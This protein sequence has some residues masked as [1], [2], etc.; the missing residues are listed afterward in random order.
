M[1]PPAPFSTRRQGPRWSG[2]ASLR[3]LRRNSDVGL[4]AHRDTFSRPLRSIQQNDTITVTT[5][6]GAYRY[7]VVSTKVVGPEDIQVLYA[8]GRDTLT[9]VT[10]FPF[11]YVNA[12]F[13]VGLDFTQHRPTSDDL[14]PELTEF[15]AFFNILNRQANYPGI[16]MCLGRLGPLG[17]CRIHKMAVK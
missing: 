8:M 9:L 11:D 10:C 2:R 17:G 4:A 7:R 15:A 6:Q 14:S 13:K 12:V 3:V 5:L 1:L 16:T